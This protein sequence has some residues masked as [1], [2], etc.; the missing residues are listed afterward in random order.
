M[1]MGRSLCSRREKDGLMKVI[2]L[3]EIIVTYSPTIF[4]AGISLFSDPISMELALEEARR[5][6]EDLLF[7]RYR[8][9]KS[10]VSWK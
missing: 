3:N 6:G 7:A 8:V 5:L 10:I 4:G 1:P 2:M 9:I